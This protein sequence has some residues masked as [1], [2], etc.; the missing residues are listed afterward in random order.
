MASQVP[1]HYAQQFAT[2][3]QLLLQQK[4]SRLMEAVTVGGGHYGE[5][6]SPVD[7]YGAITAN[8]VV[9]R[10][11]P[12][13]NTEAPTSRRWVTPTDYDLNQL[14]DSFD[15]LRLL[16][17][18]TSMYVKNAQNAIGRAMDEEILEKIFGNNQV[19]KSG[20]TTQAFGAGQTVSVIQGAASATNLTVAKLREA[21]RILRARNVDMASEEIYC[22]INAANHDALLAE[23]QVISSDFNGG[24]TP[25]V[26]D[27]V[28]QF[29]GVKFIHTELLPT[30][31]D[32]QAGTSTQT[33]VFAKSGV[34]LGMWAEMQTDIDQRK[35][36]QGLPYQ[37]YVKA[38]F[39]A[40]R[41]EE[42]KIVR[43]WTR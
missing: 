27:K 32:D 41:L 9:G 5:Q 29:L 30:G 4:G 2:T 40:T 39:G 14:I 33:P 43:I 15:K 24:K 19:G 1:T 37:A 34:Y 38:T 6:A 20:T 17:D 8:K 36:L 35:D 25:L 10:Y 42:N 22:I 3:L 18:P 11:N 7:Q 16:V 31:T 26:Q 21:K 23:V 28:E 12:M 13:P